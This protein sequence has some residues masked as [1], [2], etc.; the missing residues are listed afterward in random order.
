MKKKLTILLILITFLLTAPTLV[1]AAKKRVRKTTA[2]SYTPRG[3]Q[4]QVRFR[5]D[6]LGILI[7]FSNF[8]NLESGSYELVYEANGVAQAAGGSIIL[9]DTSTK[10]LLFATCSGGVC[11]FHENITN[12]R[13]SITSKLKDG[14][15][16]LKPYR[17]KV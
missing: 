13:L 16:V 14:T 11:N 17:L 2:P 8:D 5:P 15:T 10:E 4:S 9:G 6:R 12:A 7:N 3:V 1:S